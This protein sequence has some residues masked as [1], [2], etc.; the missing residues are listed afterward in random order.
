MAT[1]RTFIG[2]DL[3]GTNMQIG[4]VGPDHKLRG[5]SRKKTKAEEGSKGVI[6]RIVAG[7]EE[8]C[9][10]AGVSVR[11]IS[12][13]G[14]GAPGAIDPHT[15]TVLEA[16]NLRW[17]NV[18]LAKIL[19]SRIG[20]P[21]VVDNDVR[22]AA[23]GEHRLG[24]GKGATDM[25]AAWIGTGIGGG[26]ILRNHLYHGFTNTAGEFGHATLFPHI[27]PGSRS[28]ENNCSRGAIARRLLHLINTNNVSHITKLVQRDRMDGAKKR[29]L[30]GKDLQ[31]F[32]EGPL[33]PDEVKSRIINEAWVSD[34]ALTKQVVEDA[35]SNLG[36]G[37]A[38]LVTALGLQ[39]VVIG[40]GLTEAMGETLVGLVR[41][42]VRKHAFPAVAKKVE[43]V[44]TKLKEDAGLLGA[45]LL[46]QDYR[47]AR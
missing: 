4:V 45:S 32:I 24:A 7:I 41:T 10:D 21:V 12:A 9:A 34:D 42:S 1:A 30:A 8:A 39:R 5:R 47:P 13:V 19:K 36:I 18:P 29:G 31:K 14:I 20:K 33:N 11:Q 3:G 27:P 25:L 22:S 26:L 40:G 2:I 46:A 35:A 15:G 38:S 17:N 43:V 6:D 44:A 28:I 16:P 37:I 23:V